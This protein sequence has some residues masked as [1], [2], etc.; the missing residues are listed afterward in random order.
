[1]F[2]KAAYLLLAISVI[3]SC[4][5][6]RYVKPLKKNEQVASLSFGGPLILF[7][8]AAIPI[9]FTT[10][11]YAYGLTDKV[12]AYSHL[13][14]TSLLFS[15]L[16]VD[17]G[18]TIG[19]YEKANQYGFSVSPALQIATSLKAKNSFR[20]WPSTDLNFYF[21]PKEK[22]SYFYSGVNAW[23]DF[24]AKKAHNEIQNTNVLPNLQCGYVI[25]KNKYNH[26][27]QLSYLGLGTPNL[28][29]VPSFVG[30]AHQGSLGVF[31]SLIRKFK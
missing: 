24:S 10:L 21:H 22:Q 27:F 12:T 3:T 30:L 29:N 28:P 4:A 11:G 31:Y 23:F 26:Q 15:N 17:L 7:A 9:P 1:M 18:T 20:I 5:P 6:A 14:T 13:H 16:Q 2:K 19:L 25:V 8:G